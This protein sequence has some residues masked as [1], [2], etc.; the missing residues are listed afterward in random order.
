MHEYVMAITAKLLVHEL[1][2]DRE[3]ALFCAPDDWKDCSPTQSAKRNP[4]I[5]CLSWSV[6]EDGTKHF[7]QDQANKLEQTARRDCYVISRSSDS[8]H[9]RRLTCKSLQN[10]VIDIEVGRQRQ[11]GRE[12]GGDRCRVVEDWHD[13]LGDRT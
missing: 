4:A 11:I 9:S 10:K 6:V 13:C 3:L 5:V 8:K 2:G 1:V 12:K 7:E